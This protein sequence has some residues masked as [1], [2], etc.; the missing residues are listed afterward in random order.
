MPATLTTL[1]LP[2]PMRMGDVNAYLLHSEAG[3]FLIDTG[4][5]NAR[6]QLL[7]ELTTQAASWLA[8]AGAAHHGGFRN[9][10]RSLRL[11]SQVGHAPR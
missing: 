5:S 2:M 11:W 1:K 6:K 8:Q 3:Y 7:S 4:S 10:E 9:W